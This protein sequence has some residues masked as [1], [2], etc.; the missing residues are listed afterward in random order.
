MWLLAHQAKLQCSNQTRRLKFL[1]DP[2]NIS[3]WLNALLTY[4]TFG[5]DFLNVCGCWWVYE[6]GIGFL[7]FTLCSNDTVFVLEGRL[8]WRI[9]NP[10]YFV[11]MREKNNAHPGSDL[12]NFSIFDIEETSKRDAKEKNLFG[13]LNLNLKK[14]RNVFLRLF[15]FHTFPL[16]FINCNHFFV[17][18]I[19]PLYV[20]VD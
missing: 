9:Y 6:L 7:Y 19:S 8:V 4:L 11:W 16:L 5:I 3:A 10:A 12:L 17:R 14:C 2:S 15:F 13:L 1:Q 18:L 20:F